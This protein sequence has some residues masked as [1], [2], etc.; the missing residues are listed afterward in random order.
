[1]RRFHAADSTQRAFALREGDLP[2]HNHVARQTSDRDRRGRVERLIALQ[3]TALQLLANRKLNLPLSGHAQLL[4]ELPHRYVE[5]LFVHRSSFSRAITARPPNSAAHR[6]S[7]D[8]GP[9]PA[10]PRSTAQ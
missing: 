6:K 3:V 10:S 1:M 4:E 9:K 5:D 2:G 7:V 8:L